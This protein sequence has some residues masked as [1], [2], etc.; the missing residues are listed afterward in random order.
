MN[1]LRIKIIIS[2]LCAFFISSFLVSNLFLSATTKIKDESSLAIH[3][4]PLNVNHTAKSLFSLIRQV[5]PIK[6]TVFQPSPTP[7]NLVNQSLLT[8]MPWEPGQDE[9]LP[10]TVPVLTP[11]PIPSATDYPSSSL[12]PTPVEYSV[13]P[14]IILPTRVN[15]PTATP[16][17]PTPTAYLPTATPRLPTA[18]TPPPTTSYADF[19]RCLTSHGMKMYTQPGC[20]ACTQQRNLLKEAVNYVI[21][22]NCQTNVQE[23]SRIGVRSKP[24]WGK[25]NQLVIG[26]VATI[27]RLAQVSG[28][29]VPR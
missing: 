21:D 12:S 26:G 15:L 4:F 18:I 20:S 24:S 9:I 25:N 2:L 7:I 28:C 6:V 1:Q 5:A 3:N 27:E 10:K 29:P 22:I 19:G 23:C 14:T 13:T 17:V 16:R 11:L 8:P